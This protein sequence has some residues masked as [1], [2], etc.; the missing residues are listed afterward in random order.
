MQSALHCGSNFLAVPTAL[1][2]L[3]TPDPLY[4]ARIIE[5]SSTYCVQRFL[6]T[7]FVRV[8]DAK[9]VTDVVHR[10]HAR[11]AGVVTVNF[12]KMQQYPPTTHRVRVFRECR[13][14]RDYHTFTNAFRDILKRGSG[15]RLLFYQL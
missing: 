3:M 14:G 2:P 9:V 11:I 12:V 7:C 10:S 13:D 8:G 5:R 6:S 15:S 4:Y 1:G